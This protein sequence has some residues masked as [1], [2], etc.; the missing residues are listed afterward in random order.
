MSDPSKTH[1]EA[2]NWILTYLK[3][4]Q[5]VVLLFDSSR[6]DCDYVVRDVMQTMHRV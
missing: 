2:L 3:G 6:N 1:R 5:D 4:S